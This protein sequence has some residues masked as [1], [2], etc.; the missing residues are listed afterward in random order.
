MRMFTKRISA[1]ILLGLLFVGSLA[2]WINIV[3]L[4]NAE[5]IPYGGKLVACFLADVRTKCAAHSDWQYTE[6]G[7]I[8]DMLLYD[9]PL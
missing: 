5:E 2:A 4:S 7:C 6:I 9:M 8:L 3:S 1:Y